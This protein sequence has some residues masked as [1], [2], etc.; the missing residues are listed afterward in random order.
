[1][2]V[3]WRCSTPCHRRCR[4]PG[5]SVR[6]CKS[7]PRC[8]AAWGRNGQRELSE[9]LGSLYEEAAGGDTRPAV[10]FE[11]R[12]SIVLRRR[13]RAPCSRGSP[14][15][16]TIAFRRRSGE[17]LDYD[18]VSQ[19][20]FFNFAGPQAGTPHAAV[21]TAG[22]TEVP[23]AMEAVRTLQYSGIT[24]F[25][26]FD[27]GV[28]GIWR[29]L[30]RI[31]EVKRY[32]IAIVAAGMDAALPVPTSVGYGVGPERPLGSELDS[33]IVCLRHRRRKRRHGYGAACIALRALNAV[34]TQPIQQETK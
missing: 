1:M 3:K 5:R 26:L 25:T 2:P 4:R 7:G 9:T 14:R 21:L 34:P 10:T 17:R 18:R 13:A 12:S 27:C 29:L 32:P 19:T 24:S 15:T 28:A 31:E 23:V 33:G 22:S 20:E 30:D 8:S 6:D 11:P 16:A